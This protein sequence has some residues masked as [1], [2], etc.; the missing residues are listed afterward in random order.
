MPIESAR[1]GAEPDLPPKPERREFLGIHFDLL[2]LSQIK[3]ILKERS[4]GAGFGYIVTPNVDHMVRLAGSADDPAVNRA[5]ESAAMCL[6]DSRVLAALAA[7]LGVRL[8]VVP[9]SDLTET[10]LNDVADPGDTIAIVGSNERARAELQKRY[11]GVRFVQH[12]PPMGV[13]HDEGAMRAAA[14]FIASS[15]ARFT[16]IAI[17]SPQQELLAAQAARAGVAHGVGFCVGAA[18]DFLTGQEKRAPIFL[19][20]AGLEWAYRL[21]QNPRRMWR[22][23]LLEGPRIFILAAR[24]KRAH[25]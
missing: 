15:G 8:S 1:L 5:Y 9:G 14:E 25:K 12:V 16:F 17:G 18:I 10:I 13:R 24:W 20:R 3:N 19:R 4:R 6:C 22:R 11:P 2:S 7:L 23:Y 21:L